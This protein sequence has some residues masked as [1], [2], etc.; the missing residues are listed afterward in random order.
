MRSRLGLEI[1]LF[2]WL[3]STMLL[4]QTQPLSTLHNLAPNQ[5]NKNDSLSSPACNYCH[6]SHNAVPQVEAL[7]NHKIST[8][9]YQF[10]SSSTYKEGAQSVTQTSPSRLCMSCH[11]GTVG[12]GSTYNSSVPNVV[13]TPLTSAG[14]MGVNLSGSHPFSFDQWNRDSSLVDSLFNSSSRTTANSKVKLPNGRIECVTCHDPH[15]QNLD[16]KRPTDF[17]VTDNRFGTICLACH[18]TSKPSPAV[19]AGWSASAHA[20]SSSKEGANVTGYAT[21]GAGAC[22]NC[23][24]MHRSETARL[25]IAADE[26]TC[27][28]CHANQNSSNRWGRTWLGYNQKNYRHPVEITGHDPNE[29]LLAANTPRHSKCWD[30]H[31]THA[32]L[33][34]SKSAPAALGT[35]LVGANG[36]AS[37]GSN[38][39]VATLEYQVCLKCHGDS[40]N[41]PQKAGYAD[42]GYTPVRVINAFNVRKDFNSQVARHNVIWPFSG[43]AYPDLRE[44]ILMLNNN[45]GRALKSPGSYL[46][47]TDCHNGDS[48][49]QDGGTGPNGP[50]ISSTPHLLERPYALNPAPNR[51]QAVPSLVV[52]VNPQTGTF[53]MCEKCHDLSGLLGDGTTVGPKDMVF[54]HHGTHV[55]NM[56]IS[57]AVCHTPHGVDNGTK[58]F[59]AHSINL[60]TQLTGPDPTTRKWYI[61]T[62]SRICYVSCHFTNDSGTP[63]VHSGTSY[64]TTV[65]PNANALRQQPARR[66]R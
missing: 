5:S 45:A 64:D 57:C 10:H 42:Y 49:S 30:C 15:I 33:D 20:I 47:C 58:Q 25:L 55:L 11:D 4:A 39:A 31:N 52:T 54:K 3:G 7:W 59:N 1:L 35:A 27:Y 61:D 60:D 36:I 38:L 62:V 16:I 32:T 34:G 26:Q 6:T 2:Y 44:N 12:L 66:H 40:L 29:N 14:N 17:L 21:V 22:G 53:A 50:H 48:P 8:S 28:P 51:G 43:V 37:D 13:R 19:L 65:R 18:D 56:G 9:N 24:A 46:M 41:K 63:V 23:H